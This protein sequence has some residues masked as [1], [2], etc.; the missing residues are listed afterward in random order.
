MYLLGGGN[1]SVVLKLVI[2]LVGIFINKIPKE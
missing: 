2:N 1:H